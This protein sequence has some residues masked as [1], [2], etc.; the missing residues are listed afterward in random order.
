MYEE[1]FDPIHGPLGKGV[2]EAVYRYLDR[3]IGPDPSSVDAQTA[4]RSVLD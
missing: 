3:A 2:Q 4:L 1:R